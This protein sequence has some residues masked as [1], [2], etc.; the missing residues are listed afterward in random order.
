MTTQSNSRGNFASVSGLVTSR[1][2]RLDAGGFQ[3]IFRRRAPPQAE[4]LVAQPDQFRSQRQTD[5]TAADN[6]GISF[7]IYDMRFTIVRAARN[8]ATA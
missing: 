2:K 4:N 5:I 7:M 8:F 6:Q 3:F 1:D